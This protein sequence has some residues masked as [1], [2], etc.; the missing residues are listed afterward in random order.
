ML[1]ICKLLILK[2][3]TADESETDKPPYRR[4]IFYK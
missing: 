1:F 3:E 4:Y 2:T